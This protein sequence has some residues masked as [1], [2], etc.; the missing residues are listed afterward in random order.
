MNNMKNKYWLFLLLSIGIRPAGAQSFS[1]AGIVTSAA[2]S[3]R[4]T[5]DARAGGMG[6][7]GIATSADAAS[8][9][10]NLSKLPFAAGRTSIA[11]SYT[12]W[13][14][15]VT[16][17]MYLLDITGYHR[18]DTFQAIGASVRY[19]ELR[20]FPLQDKNGNTLQ[21]AHPYELSADFGYARRLGDRLSLGLAFRYIN[22]SLVNGFVDGATYK[23]GEAFA[24]DLSLFYNGL[25]QTGSGLSAG[26]VLSNL[27]S[28]ISYSDNAA[29][30][31]FLPADLGIGLAYTTVINEDHKLTF[32]GDIHHLLVPAK[33][34]DSA[35][36]RTYYD[37]GLTDSWARSFDDISLQYSTGLEYTYK[38][39]FSVR[40]GYFGSGKTLGDR[41]GF[42]AGLGLRYS[43][44]GLD[45]S[46][47]APSGNGATRN[48]YSNT[49]RL[50][51]QF[52]IQ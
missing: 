1:S 18:L 6:E 16:Q 36:I 2:P 21:T 12:P 46:Y 17:G 26:L 47:L 48:P 30:K 8:P 13:M 38:G 23:A 34:V 24:A 20:E 28:R 51:I 14:R 41:K 44:W 19:F 45:L 7:T 39:M 31:D 52:N 50:S 27:G 37:R 11:E 4:I 15:D 42:T 40:A 5:P 29:A 32:A 43:F 35:G 10:W 25:D 22:S 33:P 3:L 9:Y 49:L